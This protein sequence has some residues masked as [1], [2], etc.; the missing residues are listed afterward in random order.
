MPDA[1]ILSIIFLACFSWRSTKMTARLKK[2]RKARGHVSHGH[3]RVGKHRKHPGGCGNAGG[4]HHHRINFDKYHPG[5]F[6]K[7]GMRH[8]HM[9]RNQY[10]CPTINLDKVWTLVSKQTLKHYAD[11]SKRLQSLMLFK[12]DTSRCWERDFFPSS[13]SSWK[14]VTSAVVL[15]R[16]SSKSEVFA[17][18]PL[19]KISLYLH[20]S[21]TFQ[22]SLCINNHTLFLESHI[23]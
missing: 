10:A 2:T 15:R 8:F 13:Q 6:G 21:S 23:K 7:V 12:L 14:R 9:K 1:I 3:G 18:S 19:N 22:N 16:R 20:W 4:Q 5:Y 11:K 17:S